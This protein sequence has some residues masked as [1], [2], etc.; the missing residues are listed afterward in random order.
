VVVPLN[1]V[2]VPVSSAVPMK[3]VLSAV[4]VPS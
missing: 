3:A 2:H 1:D 4:S